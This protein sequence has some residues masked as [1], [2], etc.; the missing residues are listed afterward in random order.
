MVDGATAGEAIQALIRI[1]DGL[2]ERI[3]TPDGGLRNFVNLYVRGND[4]RN[5]EGLLTAVSDGDILSIVPAV[6]GGQL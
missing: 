5:L 2:R 4:I 3:L 1:H 6:A